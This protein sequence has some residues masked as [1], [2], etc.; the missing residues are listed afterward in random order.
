LTWSFD[1]ALAEVK[2][3]LV[4]RALL[5]HFGLRKPERLTLGIMQRTLTAEML[6]AANFNEPVHE[7][8]SLLVKPSNAPNLAV[9][10]ADVCFV[11][12]LRQRSTFFYA[13][14]IAMQQKS[15][16]VMR[17]RAKPAAL[18]AIFAAE[19]MKPAGYCVAQQHR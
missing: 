16:R 14:R 4:E 8:H 6:L 1:I 3:D 19:R 17:L 5:P 9:F 7:L 12:S 15:T 11:L 13:G 10:V 2:R 18:E